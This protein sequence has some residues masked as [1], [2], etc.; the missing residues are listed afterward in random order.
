[1]ITPVILVISVI[2]VMRFIGIT[3]AVG[4][5]ADRAGESGELGRGL[6]D[7]LGVGRRLGQLGGDDGEGPDRAG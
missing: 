2:G 6:A 3:G 1:L 4:V 7:G 5:G